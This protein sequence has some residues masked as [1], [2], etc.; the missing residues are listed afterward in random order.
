MA[1]K[2]TRKLIIRLLRRGVL[3]EKAVRP[4]TSLE[5][6]EAIEGALLAVGVSGGA[7]PKWTDFL[8]LS[9]ERK[10][11]LKNF[12]TYGLL[13]LIVE[14]RWFAVAFGNGFQKLH[15]NSYEH[16]FGL[17][18]VINAVDETKLRSA[19]LRTPDENTTTTRTQASRNSSQQI[20]EIDHERDLVRGLEGAPRD[21]EF[22]SRVAGSDALAMWK[23]TELGDLPAICK[24]A[25]TIFG[26]KDYQRHF[27]WID[28][29][30]HERDPATIDRLNSVLVDALRNALAGERPESLHLAWPII[31]NI[32]TAG[33]V[34]YGGFRS[35]LIFNDLDI[36][37]Y[38]DELTA[39]KASFTVEDLSRHF[40]E[41]TDEDGAPSG[42]SFTIHDCL[43]FET[44]MDS[45]KFVLSGGRWYEVAKSLA[46]QVSEFFNTAPR[47]EM[48]SAQKENEVEYNTRLRI[49]K[50]NDWI[51]LDADPI[52]P[53]DAT[54]SIEICDFFQDPR[55]FIHVKDQAASSK[56]SHLFNQGY[57]S[58]LTF[59]VDGE[60]RQ[61]FRAKALELSRGKMGQALPDKS[62]VVDASQWTIVFAVLREKPARGAPVLPFFSLV[63][64]RQ[65]AKRLEA[66]GFK[67]AFAWVIKEEPIPGRPRTKR[68]AG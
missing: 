68:K 43:V 67:Y 60:F 5:P 14:E 6:F 62:G 23:R 17:R 55:H 54:T 46:S 45:R 56:L 16:D 36:R 27:Q 51:C 40:I 29:I 24:E 8:E 39:K 1:K 31:Y 26:S 33:Y 65:I 49:E 19:D 11:R 41:Q 47:F 15:P 48:P 20:F 63:T 7:S 22:A 34:R 35:T 3:P 32:E 58:A 10:A 61:R 30:R 12:G 13:F 53:S 50:K 64:F 38:I 25:L 2:P 44:E 18:V 37:N 21:P 66:I 57:V 9:D 59:K 28:D 42:D 4:G 52:K